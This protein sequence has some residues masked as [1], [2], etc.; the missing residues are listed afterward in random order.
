[1][2]K[3]KKENYYQ[4][5]RPYKKWLLLIGIIVVVI[6]VLGTIQIC[7]KTAENEDIGIKYNVIDVVDEALG[8]RCKILEFPSIKN[9]KLLNEIY[10]LIGWE[11]NDYSKKGL[12]KAINKEKNELANDEMRQE[13]LKHYSEYEIENGVSE[14]WMLDD[15]SLSIYSINNNFITIEYTFNGSRGGVWLITEKY[16]TFDKKSEQIIMI[17]DI[18]IN[19]EDTSEWDEILRNYLKTHNDCVD[20]APIPVSDVFYFDEQN[21]TFVY[22]KYEIAC[23]ADG[24]VHITVPFSAIK[25]YLKTEFTTY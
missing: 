16:I 22:Q 8:F 12:L 2:K 18:L 11:L 20:E 15:I 14:C 19:R 23:G 24:V 4:S 7:V 13:V 17:S 6:A 25:S 5:S 3:V 1:M 21:I 9:K 10:G